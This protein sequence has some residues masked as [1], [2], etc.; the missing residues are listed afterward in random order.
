VNA[1]RLEFYAYAPNGTDIFRVGFEYGPPKHYVNSTIM[2][3]AALRSRLEDLKKKNN[4]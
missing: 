4:K 1:G 2:N 3:A